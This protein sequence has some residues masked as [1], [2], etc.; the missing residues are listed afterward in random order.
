MESNKL[1]RLFFRGS[2]G[3]EILHASKE[4]INATR[5]FRW[6]WTW[7]G[8]GE[9]NLRRLV[10][11]WLLQLY[12]FDV[13]GRKHLAGQYCKDAFLGFFW[14]SWYQL[15]HGRYWRYGV[16]QHSMV[17]VHVPCLLYAIHT[18]HMYSWVSMILS[19]LSLTSNV[20]VYAY[21]WYIHDIHQ[22]H[23]SYSHF[24]DYHYSHLPK[25]W[26]RA[27]SIKIFNLCFFGWIFSCFAGPRL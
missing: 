6:A 7:T 15:R 23:Q 27:S 12:R 19:V 26:C 2:F 13:R 9:I 4:K 22:Y 16:G 25:I 11:F 17:S 18:I 24:F 3:I 5:W 1:I 14:F 10:E 8:I 21:L 20:N